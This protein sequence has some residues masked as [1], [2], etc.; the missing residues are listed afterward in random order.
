MSRVRYTAK[1]TADPDRVLANK[2]AKRLDERKRYSQ[3][4][5]YR[6]SSLFRTWIIKRKAWARNDLIWKDYIPV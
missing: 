4:D 6:Q 1:Q 2:E 5:H 3:D